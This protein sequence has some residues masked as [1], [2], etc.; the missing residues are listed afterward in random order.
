MGIYTAKEGQKD[1]SQH[2]MKSSK[3][4]GKT[5]ICSG[6]KNGS[7]NSLFLSH[8]RL[9][10]EQHLK[11]ARVP[12]T[13]LKTALESRDILERWRVNLTSEKPDY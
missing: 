10:C 4:K 13:K 7:R 11:H 8:V 1:L 3:E 9:R 12:S 2:L 6:E 5:I